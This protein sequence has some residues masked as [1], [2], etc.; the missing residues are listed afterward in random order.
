MQEKTREKD[1]NIYIS[2]LGD[3]EHGRPH[4]D[5]GARSACFTSRHGNNG[6]E[7]NWVKHGSFV[8]KKFL[9]VKVCRVEN[10]PN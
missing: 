3:E 10:N 6:L 9:Q 1:K 2:L 5:M 4:Y 8:P 7:G